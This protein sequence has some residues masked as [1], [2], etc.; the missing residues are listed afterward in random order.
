VSQHEWN[1]GYRWDIV[2]TGR[3][4]TLMDDEDAA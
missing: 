2:L 3:L 4:R 1:T